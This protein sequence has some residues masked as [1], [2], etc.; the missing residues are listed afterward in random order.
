MGT[1]NSPIISL[2]LYRR[3]IRPLHQ[4]VIDVA[5]S[6]G[7]PVMIHTCG[8]SSWVYEDF[9]E[10]GISTVDTLQPEA[11]DMPPSIPIN[12][13]ETPVPVNLFGYSLIHKSFIDTF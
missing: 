6:F 7:L 13:V 10:M 1:Q 8:S 9:I 5:K 2:E 4:K 11:K 12:E 3:N